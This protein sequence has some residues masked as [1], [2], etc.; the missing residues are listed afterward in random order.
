MADSKSLE[1]LPWW[2]VLG[3]VIF[4]IAGFIGMMAAIVAFVAYFLEGE[5]EVG[6]KAAWMALFLLGPFVTVALLMIVIRRAFGT[7]IKRNI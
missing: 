2:L 6:V 4:V 1:Y 5:R 3:V 7:G